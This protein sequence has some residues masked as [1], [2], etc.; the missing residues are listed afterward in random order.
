[1]G[2]QWRLKQRRRQP[3][4]VFDGELD[5]DQANMNA[6]QFIATD[7]IRRGCFEAS[8]RQVPKTRRKTKQTAVTTSTLNIADA[9]IL[10]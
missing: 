10:I 3:P 9:L 7:D 5:W 6:H 2:S 8:P 1:M 4:N